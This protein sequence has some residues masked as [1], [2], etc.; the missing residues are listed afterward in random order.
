MAQVNITDTLLNNLCVLEDIVD[1]AAH[2]EETIRFTTDSVGTASDH[3]T[4]T[5]DLTTHT[6]DIVLDLNGDTLT[7]T[8]VISGDVTTPPN[9]LAEALYDIAE[10]MRAGA[11]EIKTIARTKY[12]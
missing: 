4:I 7:F 6:L 2:G 9:G 8:S 3:V 12:P 1:D 11:D 5:T 10:L